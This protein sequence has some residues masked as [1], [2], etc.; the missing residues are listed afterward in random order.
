M[1]LRSLLRHRVALAF[2]AVL[3]VA[4]CVISSNTH[5]ESQPTSGPSVVR[6]PMKV[7]MFDGSIVVFAKMSASVIPAR[8][9]SAT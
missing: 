4:A 9:A 5:G 6:A 7:H 8:I 3:V 2:G 1:S